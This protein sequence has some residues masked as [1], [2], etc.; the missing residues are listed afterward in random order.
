MRFKSGLIDDA[1][2]H[3]EK[4]IVDITFKNGKKYRYYG[5]T[6]KLWDDFKSATSKGTF[7]HQNFKK[8]KCEEL[9]K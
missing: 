6:K 8:L 9:K 1:D 7:F 5:V 3:N 2:Y 4:S